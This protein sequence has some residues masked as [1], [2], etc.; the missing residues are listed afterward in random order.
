MTAILHHAGPHHDAYWLVKA[1]GELDI[2]TLPLL[3]HDLHAA[4]VR[5]AVPRLIIDLRPVTFLDCAGL[6]LLCRVRGRVRR[7]EGWLRLVYAAPVTVRLFGYAGLTDAFP[8]HASVD[9]ALQGIPSAARDADQAGGTGG[10]GGRG[11]PGGMGGAWGGW[12]GAGG[13]G[14]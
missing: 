4:L 1:A 14:R 10:R 9:D 5:P 6:G 7:R 8:A 11:G 13:E 3:E 12:S 2:A